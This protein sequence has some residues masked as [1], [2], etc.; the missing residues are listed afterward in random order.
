M[1]STPCACG[2]VIFIL[3]RTLYVLTL[4]SIQSEI[5][6]HSNDFNINTGEQCTENN[7]D[8]VKKM[9]LFTA[10]QIKSVKLISHINKLA[11]GFDSQI[12]GTKGKMLI[13]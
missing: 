3:N 1:H 9:T 11:S 8:P 12:L 13:F 7:I 5:N 2:E 6:P 4:Y 10:T